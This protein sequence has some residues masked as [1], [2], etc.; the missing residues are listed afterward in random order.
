MG[1]EAVKGLVVLP[2]AP[3]MIAAQP[4][5]D[6]EANGAPRGMLVTG[7]FLDLREMTDLRRV[8]RQ[9]LNLFPIDSDPIIAGELA[10]ARIVN[11]IDPPVRVGTPGEN[12]IAGYGILRDIAGKPVL[13]LRT[14][15]PRDILSQGR[16]TVNLFLGV[17]IATGLMATVLVAWFF[18]RLVLAPLA[19]LRADVAWTAARGVTS[20]RLPINGQD[21]ITATA[22]EVNR[23]LDTFEQIQHRDR[24]RHTHHDSISLTGRSP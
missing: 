19:R 24:E 7:R 18:E 16:R 13:T 1:G 8:S 4:I 12:V 23:L 20:G 5:L 14:V 9:T 3:M 21:D 6:T 2:E 17:L 22:R 15:M 11:P 10:D